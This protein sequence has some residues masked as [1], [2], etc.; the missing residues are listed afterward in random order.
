MKIQ[1]NAMC[2][3]Y[4]YRL[5]WCLSS[6]VE[7]IKPIPDLVFRISICSKMDKYSHLKNMIDNS[8]NKLIDIKW[9]NY[10]D[11]NEFGYRK[12]VRN[13]DLKNKDM[14]S[15]IVLWIDVDQIFHPSHFN[16]L[17]NN[18]NKYH[19]CN[20]IVSM[21]RINIQTD[22]VDQLI[23]SVDYFLPIKN[24]IDKINGN[25]LKLIPGTYKLGDGYYQLVSNRT[26]ERKHINRYAVY[27]KDNYLWGNHKDK[28][29]Y[30]LRSDREF[31]KRYGTC[32]LK[33]A[34]NIYH[35]DHLRCIDRHNY[36]ES[37]S[38]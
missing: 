24:C 22:I 6:I 9:I 7:Q 21:G 3:Q 5:F 28:Y 13:N 25:N 26:I 18:I 23:K 30:A 34:P 36:L 20:T 31:I 4:W 38:F 15:D 19:R 17:L 1:I 2:Y 33:D 35:L 10:E 29:H 11:E 8:F 32:E 16:F 27:T 12:N 14:T 37:E